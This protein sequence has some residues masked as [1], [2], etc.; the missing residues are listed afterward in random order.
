[1][2]DLTS[3]QKQIQKAAWEFAKG[4]FD[5]NLI[6][7]LEKKNIF[8]ESVWK[9]A[10]KLGFIGLHIDE[11]YSGGGMGV[12][13]QVLAAESFCRKDSSCGMA[14]MQAGFASEL[15]LR[16]GNKGQKERYLPFV[17]RGMGGQGGLFS[18]RARD[19][20]FPVWTPWQR[21]RRGSG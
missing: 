21:K 7:E 13:E 12:L 17:A 14:L 11:A 4:E 10:T 8:P 6:L 2:H 20:I 15:I 1:M 5:K 3:A 19:M 9:K 18:R 16:F